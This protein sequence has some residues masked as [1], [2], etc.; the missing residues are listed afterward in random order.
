MSTI[1]LNWIYE[2]NERIRDDIFWNKD[3]FNTY[4]NSE[5]LKYSM[6]T[7][8]AYKISCYP[9]KRHHFG[10]IT[11]LDLTT[12]RPHEIIG[13]IIEITYE[14]IKIE[15]NKFG[16]TLIPDSWLDDNN[17]NVKDIL[18]A[19][20]FII[21]KENIPSI[22]NIFLAYRKKYKFNFI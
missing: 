19:I 9:D 14:G 12:I 5:I 21:I 2:D 20:P 22:L 15:L 16:E 18:Y 17:G 4:K 7:Y 13:D 10:A 3:L 1:S 8:G 11:I 6:N